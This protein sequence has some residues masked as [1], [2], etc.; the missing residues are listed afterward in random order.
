MWK[1]LSPVWQTLISTLLLV[2]AVSALYFCGYQ[3]AAKQADADKAEI[4]A[5][6][7]ASA[8]AAEQQYAAKLAEAAAEKQKWMDFAQQQSRDLAA[9]YQEIDRQAAQLEKQID[10]TVQKDGGGFNGIGSDSVRLYNRALGHA[11]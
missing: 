4:I 10:E 5:T 8:L 1:T 9:A 6:Y 2:A 11:D 7:Q 3:A